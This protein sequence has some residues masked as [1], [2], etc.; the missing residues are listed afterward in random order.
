MNREQAKKTLLAM[1]GKQYRIDGKLEDFQFFSIH[2]K[3]ERVFITTNAFTRETTLGELEE[4]LKIYVE[5]K[6]AAVRSMSE[7]S[8]VYKESSATSQ[9]IASLPSH[10]GESKDKIHFT[11]DYGMFRNITGNRELNESKIKRIVKDINNGLNMLSYCPIIVDGEFNVIDGQHRLYIAKK[12]R[13]P[14]YFIVSRNISLHEIASI[15]SNTER[16]KGKDF[17][18][19]YASQGNEHYIKLQDFIDKYGFPI[20]TAITLLS[21]AEVAQGGRKKDGFERGQF[22]IEH[23]ELAESIAERVMLFKE[24]PKYKSR[25]FIEAI[26]KLSQ[27]P[28]CDFEHLL[29]K[30][31]EDP[32]E[33]KPQDSTKGYMQA[34]EN[35][36]NIKA[37]SRKAIY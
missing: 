25:P 37:K 9:A 28:T 3:A 20:T 24:F 10:V 16:W 1:K 17:I 5:K 31:N 29:K 23:H 21:S 6:P 22:K 15:N 14:V 13:K 35:V 33:L 8:S 32:K 30:F 27:S 12:L 4:H 11:T 26:T 34:L 7:I 36:Y 18:H 2:P 19:C